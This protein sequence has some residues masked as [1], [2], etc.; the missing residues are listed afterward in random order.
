MKN[1]L[2]M[3]L[4]LLSINL[5]ADDQSKYEKVK[6][7]VESYQSYWEQHSKILMHDLLNTNDYQRI[8]E[9]N[10]AEGQNRAY[11]DMA[12]FISWLEQSDLSN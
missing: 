2:F 1:L 6:I 12:D 11:S 3:T 5:F 8:A 4:S 7:M 10:Q 9:Y